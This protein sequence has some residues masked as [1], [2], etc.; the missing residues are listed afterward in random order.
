MN[1][2]YA[3]G[4][5]QALK[6]LFYIVLHNYT[7]RSVSWCLWVPSLSTVPP[8]KLN[9]TVIFTAIEPSTTAPS[10]CAANIHNGLWRKSNT[11][12]NPCSQSFFSLLRANSLSSSTEMLYLG[13]IRG[14]SDKIFRNFSFFSW[15]SWSNSFVMLDTSKET[16]PQPSLSFCGLAFCKTFSEC[17]KRW[18]VPWL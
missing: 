10:S 6:P 11:E 18:R 8:N 9:C 14:S 3:F 5:G 13:F 15:L 4:C 2:Q 16:A 17:D 12:M 7:W 1:S